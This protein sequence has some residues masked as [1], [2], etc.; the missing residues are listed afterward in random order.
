VKFQNKRDDTPD[1]TLTVC[2]KWHPLPHPSS[3]RPLRPC[4]GASAPVL[5]HK[6]S[7]CRASRF[8]TSWAGSPTTVAQTFVA[9][10]SAHSRRPPR[11]AVATAGLRPF[12]VQQASPSRR[13]TG[14]VATCVPGLNL[15]TEG[16]G[17]N[18]KSQLWTTN[19]LWTR[20]IQFCE[21][22]FSWV[23]HKVGWKRNWKI[24][25]AIFYGIYVHS[26]EMFHWKSADDET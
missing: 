23:F 22:F 15:G 12:S 6:L 19:A 5:G 1:G 10:M 13:E 21:E 16:E 3:A 24:F 7:C 18:G 14:R 26:L 4:T 11:R 2:G 25:P 9:Q 8:V 17:R 20:S